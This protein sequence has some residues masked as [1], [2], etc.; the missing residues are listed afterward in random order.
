MLRLP[1]VS[2]P[3][4]EVPTESIEVQLDEVAHFVVLLF[5][6]RVKKFEVDLP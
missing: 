3:L 6:L 1:M 4:F 2:L 5:E